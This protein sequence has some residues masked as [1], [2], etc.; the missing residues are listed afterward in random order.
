MSATPSTNDLAAL[1][2]PVE[3]RDGSHARIRQG[4]RSDRELLLRGFERLS[5]E[6]RYRRFLGPIPELSKA[7]VRYLTE[8]DHH[9]H[10]AMIALDERTGEGIGVARYVR[11]SERPDVAEVAVT[12]I[13]DWQGKGLGTLLLDVISARAREEGIRSFTALMLAT[14]TE[15]MDLLRE[16]DPVWI[17]DRETGTVEIEVPIPSVGLAPSLRKLIRIAAQNDVAV[18]LAHRHGPGPLS[19]EVDE[20]RPRS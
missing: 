10:E 14:N 12:V 8:I 2:A 18:P 13:D 7:M 1:G 9:D 11:N 19:G 6:S 3:L 4:H 17:V 15:M 20:D 5:P 16:L